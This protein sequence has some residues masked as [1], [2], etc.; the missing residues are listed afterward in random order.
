METGPDAGSD[1]SVAA[2]DPLYAQICSVAVTG[3]AERGSDG[4]VVVDR[5]Q[6]LVR[7]VKLQELTL[8]HASEAVVESS[9]KRD[10]QNEE[11][12]IERLREVISDMLTE[13]G[14]FYFVVLEKDVEKGHVH[15]LKI[16]RADAMTMASQACDDAIGNH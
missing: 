11:A 13:E 4:V 14:K 2:R 15:I 1:V 9:S 8:D 3:E 10:S 5:T 12:G 6:Q 16:A 7:W